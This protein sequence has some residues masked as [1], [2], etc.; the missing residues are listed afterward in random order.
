MTLSELNK[1]LD[2]RHSCRAF[3]PDPI[4]KDQ[5]EQILTSAA[6]VP[7]WC[8]AQPWDVIV[9]SGAQTDTFRKALQEEA[10]TGAPAPDL[11]F[12]TSYSGVYKDRRRECGWAL[13]K[14]VGVERGDRSASAKQMMQN[15]TLCGARLQRRVGLF[16]YHHSGA[17]ETHQIRDL[18]R[19]TCCLHP[20][21]N[22]ERWTSGSTQTVPL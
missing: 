16:L 15:F 5:I 12:P 2:E 19:R 22:P 10:T 1:L 11:P 17:L 13:Y 3:C 6:R 21:A 20:D 4:P 14:A 7:S 18:S 8:N 9:T